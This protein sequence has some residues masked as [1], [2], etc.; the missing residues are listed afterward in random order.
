ML[1]GRKRYSTLLIYVALGVVAFSLLFF[2][3]HRS[4]ELPP[5]DVP[6]PQAR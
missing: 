5:P 1:A 6:I 4:R 3:V 2:A